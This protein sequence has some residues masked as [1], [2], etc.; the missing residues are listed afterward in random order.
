MRTLSLCAQGAV[1]SCWWTTGWNI[2]CETR[3]SIKAVDVGTRLE[4]KPSMFG[5]TVHQRSQ[6]TG[7]GP[8]AG[9]SSSTARRGRDPTTFARR[10]RGPDTGLRLTGRSPRGQR[11]FIFRVCPFLPVTVSRQLSSFLNKA[12]NLAIIIHC[13]R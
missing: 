6:P 3:R 2:A 9:S 8:S 4:L 12:C 13:C 11:V 7:L 5:A 10:A 1:K